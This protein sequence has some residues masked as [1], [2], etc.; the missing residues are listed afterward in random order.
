[1][2][3]KLPQG[4]ESHGVLVTNTS[5]GTPSQSHL[6]RAPGQWPGKLCLTRASVI[7]SSA[8]FPALPK[9]Y[10]GLNHLRILLKRRFW[11][12]R[13]GV[14]HRFCISNKLPTDT[15]FSWCTDH[16]LS[17]KT[18]HSNSSSFRRGG[19]WGPGKERR[20]PTSR[21]LDGG[22]DG[23]ALGTPGPVVFPYG[24]AA[25]HQ[26]SLKAAQL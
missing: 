24:Q 14:G 7:P 3:P 25:Y 18:L 6:I 1:M 10:C 11:Y 16:T 5:T 4:C 26:Q 17:S 12:T 8:K 21:R 13:F 19:N 2:L 9:L 23:L 22:R 20:L 15:P